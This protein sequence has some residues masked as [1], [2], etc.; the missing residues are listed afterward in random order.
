MPP[1]MRA[2]ALTVLASAWIVVLVSPRNRRAIARKLADARRFVSHRLADTEARA[3]SRAVDTW[4]GEGGAMRGASAAPDDAR[5]S[6][7]IEP[8]PK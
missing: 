4:E 7:M 3:S 5:A 6:M 1:T 2:I 8:A